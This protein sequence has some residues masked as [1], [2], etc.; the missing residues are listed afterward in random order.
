MFYQGSR[1][2]KV[3]WQWNGS[4]VIKSFLNQTASEV[5]LSFNFS[6]YLLYVSLNF[7][8]LLSCTFMLYGCECASVCMWRSVDSSW[9]QFSPFWLLGWNSGLL[10]PLIYTFSGWMCFMAVLCLSWSDTRCE[11]KYIRGYK[12]FPFPPKSQ[13]TWG[14]RI[15]L[16]CTNLNENCKALTIY[17]CWLHIFV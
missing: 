4:A 11:L 12:L 7:Y 8:V 10:T 15:L 13:G 17:V 9:S 2:L 6:K 16:F 14:P 3:C 1:T 5:L